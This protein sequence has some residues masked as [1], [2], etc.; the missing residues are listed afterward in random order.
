[1]LHLEAFEV[2]QRLRTP[3]GDEFTSYCNKLR[4][5]TA[6]TTGMRHPRVKVFAS[7]I[8]GEG[9]TKNGQNAPYD[10][11]RARQSSTECGSVAAG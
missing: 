9:K 6:S 4:F 2:M 11:L 7:N 10:G 3:G 1:M 8:E 5:F